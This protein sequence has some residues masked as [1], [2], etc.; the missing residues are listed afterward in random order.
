MIRS[1]A[2]F[3]NVQ[4]DGQVA[5][6]RKTIILNDEQRLILNNNSRVSV[7]SLAV[8]YNMLVSDAYGCYV[9]TK[10]IR[11]GDVLLVLQLFLKPRIP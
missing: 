10:L 6:F 4:A 2:K 8:L 3:V 5:T 11:V 1:L 7:T 9:C